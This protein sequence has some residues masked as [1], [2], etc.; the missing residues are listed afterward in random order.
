MTI[1]QGKVIS[2]YASIKYSKKNKKTYVYIVENKTSIDPYTGKK[3][4]VKVVLES[5][6]FLNRDVSK[7]QSKIA[8]ARYLDK[9]QPYYV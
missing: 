5:L 9:K 1:K 8:L 7:S 2:S 3:K 4:Y 6:G